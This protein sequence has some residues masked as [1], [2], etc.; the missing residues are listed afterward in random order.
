M[1]VTRRTHPRPR[2][3]SLILGSRHPITMLVAPSG[4]GKTWAA[5]QASDEWEGNRVW[6]TGHADHADPTR[7][8][9][10][11]W[12]HLVKQA[13]VTPNGPDARILETLATRLDPNSM[14]LIVV[15]EAE[16][17][18]PDA[19]LALM[20]AALADEAPFKLIVA[21]RRARYPEGIFPGIPAT[22]VNLITSAE[23]A[24]TKEEIEALGGAGTAALTRYDSHGGWPVAVATLHHQGD[25]QGGLTGLIHRTLD[26]LPDDVRELAAL[27]APSTVWSEELAERMTGAPPRGW[28]QTLLDSGLP[29]HRGGLGELRPHNLV[30]EA[31]LKELRAD[32]SL[33]RRSLISVAANAQ[34]RGDMR[35]AL[36]HLLEAQAWHQLARVLKTYALSLV[37]N[38]RWQEVVDV[39]N[40]VPL[41][42]LP[43]PEGAYLKHMAGIALVNVS[44]DLRALYAAG[45]ASQIDVEPGSSADPT[46]IDAKGKQLM[47]TALEFDADSQ[48]AHVS[49]LHLALLNDQVLEARELARA[50]WQL[51]PLDPAWHLYLG[52]MLS[53]LQAAVGGFTAAG[54][55]AKEIRLAL[56]Y[57]RSDINAFLAVRALEYHFRG[58]HDTSEIERVRAHLKTSAAGPLNEAD[59][60]YMAAVSEAML[61]QE[62]AHELLSDLEELRSRAPRPHPRSLQ[63]I[64]RYRGLA[65]M[66]DGR[67]EDGTQSLKR[68]YQLAKHDPIVRSRTIVLYHLALLRSG[69]LEEAE[70]LLEEMP[71]PRT[72]VERADQALQRASLA[73]ATGR[74]ELASTLL[75]SIDTQAMGFTAF[76]LALHASLDLINRVAAGGDATPAL[77]AMEQVL[78]HELMVPQRLW[79]IGEKEALQ[80]HLMT[81]H[82]EATRTIMTLTRALLGASSQPYV[83]T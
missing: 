21:L 71:K 80:R 70:R 42:K 33:Y 34:I 50:G 45:Y 38:H 61:R 10:D 36:S 6:I 43:A 48:V 72:D 1:T 17:V 74:Y 56:R 73:H 19:I 64:Y 7:F 58:L 55:T 52:L 57:Q 5:A 59:R 31:L 32:P 35:Q 22:S 12:R 3:T 27:L 41:E 37:L 79:W 60:L 26:T 9:N 23:L 68:A 63:F 15:D 18:H 13:H 40:P 62:R 83:Q 29:I 69:K 49:R 76:G 67:I 16:K 75:S 82:P 78:A 20:R 66:M 81:H 4:W 77:E 11:L 53:S 51:G 2:I 25:D 24:F 14:L 28:Q 39:M 54:A 65:Q 44:R 8:A 46:Y 47:K 30:R